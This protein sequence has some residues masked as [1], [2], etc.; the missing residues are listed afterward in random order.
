VGAPAPRALA[1]VEDTLA[2]FARDPVLL[3]LRVAPIHGRLSSEVKERTMRA[4]E[5]GEIQVLVATSVVEVGIDVPRATLMVIL[6]ADRFG[7]AQLHQLRGR[8]GRGTEPGVCLLVSAAPEGTAAAQ[9]L[10]AMTL[11]RDG[12]KLSEVDLQLRREGDVL[13]AEQS[14][15][16]GSLRLL[17]VIRDQELIAHT[18][19]RAADLV[20]GDPRLKEHPALL[21]HLGSRLTG[22]EEFLE[23]T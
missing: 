22:R 21:A 1:T 4:F 23:R 3:G 17:R 11:W 14:G 16:S 5:A 9:R 13:G 6:D 7:L 20:A 18:R 2:R 19:Q 10:Q 12:F 8:I 15:R